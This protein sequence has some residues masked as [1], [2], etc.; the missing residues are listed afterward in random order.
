MRVV[1]LEATSASSALQERSMLYAMTMDFAP[2]SASPS[3]V[4]RMSVHWLT[5][6]Q[7]NSLQYVEFVTLVA[8]VVSIFSGGKIHV[9][10]DKGGLE[11]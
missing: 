10:P 6:G 5:L 8:V 9:D 11:E 3:S 2:M 1:Y 4:G 7:D